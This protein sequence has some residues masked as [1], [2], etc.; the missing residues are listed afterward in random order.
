M[1]NCLDSPEK[2][3]IL[4]PIR[5]N[6]EHRKGNLWSLPVTWSV[7]LDPEAGYTGLTV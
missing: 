4:H 2:I 6:I 7:L 5:R 3:H 1:N